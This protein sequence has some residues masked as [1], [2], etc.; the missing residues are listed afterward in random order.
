MTI[1]RLM[2]SMVGDNH[3]FRQMMKD[4]ISRVEGFASVL[5]HIG[6]NLTRYISAPMGLL[7]GF[8][9]KATAELDSL[10][11]EL[12]AMTGSAE[13]ATVTFDRLIEAAKLPG[14]E[15]NAAIKTTAVLR[16]IGFTA[17]GAERS[18]YGIG[19]AIAASGGGAEE[20][21]NVA[22]QFRQVASLGRLMGEELNV[23]VENAPAAARAIQTAFGTTS[24]EAIRAMGLTTE[25]FFDRLLT[26]FESL[27]TVTGSLKNSMENLGTAIRTA[28]GRIIRVNIV[29]IQD[30][31]D[32]L[33]GYVERL[34]LA[35]INMDSVQRNSILRMVRNLFLL[36]P[37]ILALQM[38]VKTFTL[39]RVAILGLGAAQFWGTMVNFGKTAVAT[40]SLAAAI[41]GLSASFAGLG[42][43]LAT[44]GIAAL[45]IGIAGALAYLK[46]V[47][48]KQAISD[49]TELAEKMMAYREELEDIARDT[50]PGLTIESKLE[51]EQ[52]HWSRMTQA[53]AKD[54]EMLQKKLDDFN[55][56]QRTVNNQG[57]QR[58]KGDLEDAQKY[59]T[60]A[61]GML[62][63]I[64][65]FLRERAILADSAA[66]AERI[67]NEA[68]G[69]RGG[70]VVTALEQMEDL[71][72]RYVAILKT[73]PRYTNLWYEAQNTLIRLMGTATSAAEQQRDAFGETAV[74][75]RQIAHEVKEALGLVESTIDGL[76]EF[77]PLNF[78][79]E[80]EVAFDPGGLK[81]AIA[82]VQL[83]ADMR[84]GELDIGT[85]AQR[86]KA[87]SDSLYEYIIATDLQFAA[88]ER[89]RF[90]MDRFAYELNVAWHQLGNQ[91]RRSNVGETAKQGLN[92]VSDAAFSVA[93]SFGPLGII[94]T[95][96][97]GALEGV[98]PLIK[99]LQYPIYILG[100]LIG[101]ALMPVFK[102]LFPIIKQLSIGFT[103]VA[104]VTFM[105]S[106]WLLKAI[107]WV[108]EGLGKV[109]KWL[110]LGVVDQLAKAGR[111]M[112]ELGTGM[113]Q[114]ADAMA[115]ARE[116]FREMEFHDAL[117][118]ATNGLDKLTEAVLNAVDGYK[119]E[120]ARF[121][122]TRPGEA[123]YTPHIRLGERPQTN[124][125][126]GAS[127]STAPLA[128]NVTI[129]ISIN[130][131]GDG[132]ETYRNF[133]EQFDMLSRAN[134]AAR[135]I[136]LALPV[137][138]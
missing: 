67:M 126:S 136:F 102:A 119:I 2:V 80:H 95:F 3:R 100:V 106:G 55:I 88:T 132:A 79:I 38:L 1:G 111:G 87:G 121:A 86:L 49:S 131:S 138:Q 34:S 20:F 96:L 41:G 94:S 35:I 14:I 133:Y 50:S 124:T 36:G 31:I 7:G 71:A 16:G 73:V 5:Q 44:G 82:P 83:Q 127:A 62:K 39:L 23:I 122:A 117:D 30:A 68:L 108:V 61:Q 101:E 24:A 26:G 29:E 54:V 97:Q 118:A 72:E 25:E 60:E 75:Y 15:L 129:P 13:D 98:E 112:R 135:Q 92:M 8:A 99:A 46:A 58:V 43:T 12:E 27:P 114:S 66:E 28:F 84:L 47:D 63:T 116:M 21:R 74:G 48:M 33:V 109:V 70:S 128:N 17:A 56:L 78:R 107:G 120:S 104:Q 115:A 134:S 69:G 123:P 40:R 45:L 52:G 10:I 91:F 19:K 77:K 64:N 57:F 85:F 59:L 105:I 113:L 65:A 110:T 93:A 32:K 37:G 130:T 81:A 103:Y 4:S 42:A 22:R 53:A 11:R 125:P 51:W 89:T 6:T 9:L 137:P 90:E 18:I 76:P